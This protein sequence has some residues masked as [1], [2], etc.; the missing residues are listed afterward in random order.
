MVSLFLLSIERHV[1]PGIP[2]RA[3]LKGVSSTSSMTSATNIYNYCNNK[4]M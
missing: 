1:S 2:T 4:N 3:S